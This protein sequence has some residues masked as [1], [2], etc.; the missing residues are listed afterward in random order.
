MQVTI[1]QLMQAAPLLSKEVLNRINN[2]IAIR[3]SNSVLPIQPFEIYGIK[4]KL[5]FL[6]IPN[7][8]KVSL[9]LAEKFS[10]ETEIPSDTFG[11][12]ID[13]SHVVEM[14]NEGIFDFIRKIFFKIL[15]CDVDSLLKQYHEAEVGDV[16]HLFNHYYPSIEVKKRSNGYSYHSWLGVPKSE[17]GTLRYESVVLNSKDHR[18]IG[19]GSVSIVENT[20]TWRLTNYADHNPT[21]VSTEQ[22][23]YGCKVIDNF[24]DDLT[25][26]C[27]KGDYNPEWLDKLVSI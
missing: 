11:K 13:P 22:D 12:K 1:K 10:L 3:S 21:T 7:G 15:A 27:M 6:K 19:I 4:C 25:W 8:V 17:E 18:L 24:T 5:L 23:I 14:I 26:L 9:N 2:Y 20:S 16:S